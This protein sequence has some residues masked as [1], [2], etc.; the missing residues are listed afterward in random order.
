MTL[1]SRRHG[2]TGLES[3]RL[4]SNMQ[5][6][7]VK[8]WRK[9]EEFIAELTQKFPHE[10]AGIK[11]FYDECWRVFNSLNSLELK[12]LEEPK[13]LLGGLIQR[14][15]LQRKSR[16]SI[17][18]IGAMYLHEAFRCIISQNRRLYFTHQRLE[19]RVP[20]VYSH[21]LHQQW[22]VESFSAAF[23]RRKA[24][25][26]DRASSRG[27]LFEPHA[28]PEIPYDLHGK[29]ECFASFLLVEWANKHGITTGTLQAY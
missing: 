26:K 23:L 20:Q 14:V 10:E 13:Y 9:Y 17:C 24:T 28:G 27:L 22:P 16:I 3:Q 12:S 19:N 6:L 15:L 25:S 1:K 8:V 5:G 4:K 7:E 18:D 29:D 2:Q 11:K 21:P